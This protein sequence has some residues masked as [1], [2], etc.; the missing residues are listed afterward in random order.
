MVKDDVSK[1][2]KETMEL[3]IANDDVLTL[4]DEKK[5][6]DEDPSELIY[7]NIF[8]YKRIPSTQEEVKAFILVAVDVPKVSLVNYFFKQM[9]LTITVVCHAG[10]MKTSYGGTRVDLLTAAIRNILN[11]NKEYNGKRLEY[12]S[13]LEGVL[14]GGNYFYREMRFKADEIN[15]TGKC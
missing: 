12:V 15:S 1:Y 13:D 10:K 7:Q 8:P 3:L 11:G 9:M 6:V 4:I 5:I 2:K 14:T